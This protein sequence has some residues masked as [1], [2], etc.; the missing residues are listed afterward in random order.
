VED[1]I[2]REERLAIEPAAAV[3]IRYP[4]AGL[5]DDEGRRR[6]V[7]DLEVDLDHRLGRAVGEERVAP[8]VAEAALPPGVGEEAPKARSAA[9]G[10]DVDGAGVQDLGSVDAIDPRHGD[11]A[12]L[13]IASVEGPRTTA[14]P[15]EPARPESRGRDDRGLQLT[16]PLGGEEG[17]EE[18][19]AADVV[20]RSVDGVDVPPN[21]R[22]AGVRAQLLADDAVAREGRRDPVPDQPLD[23]CVRLGDERAVRLAADRH[24]TPEVPQGDL[25]GPVAPAERGLDPAAELLVGPAAKA[26]APVRSI[27]LAHERIRS[28]SG[29]HSGSRMTSKPIHSPKMSISPR[30]PNAA[31]SGGR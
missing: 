8:E 21:V 13:G 4:A 7:P 17:G 6:G 1:A 14:P 10:L 31:S 26:G 25:V 29:S 20:V 22:A 18:R 27:R 16:L 23:A 11:P 3:E 9:G 2:R 19:H 12:R 28:P 15:G 5:L 30:V 24:A